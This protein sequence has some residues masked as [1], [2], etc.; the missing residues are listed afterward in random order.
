MGLGILDRAHQWKGGQSLVGVW[1]GQSWDAPHLVRVKTDVLVLAKIFLFGLLAGR[2]LI[3][4]RLS[5]VGVGW[6]TTVVRVR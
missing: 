1:G 2:G 4:S 5:L 3:Y 6:M